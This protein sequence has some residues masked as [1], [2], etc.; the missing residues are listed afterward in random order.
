MDEQQMQF[1]DPDWQPSE[2]A[3]QGVINLGPREQPSS[4]ATIPEEFASQEIP[5]RERGKLEPQLRSRRKVWFIVVPL[6]VILCLALVGA[7]IL[8]FSSHTSTTSA[9][10]QI[11]PGQPGVA[12]L[13]ETQ[14]LPVHD[15]KPTSSADNEPIVVISDDVGS[16]HVHIGGAFD[17]VTVTATEHDGK[18]NFKGMTVITSEGGPNNNTL[19]I[20][21]NSDTGVSNTRS[22][23]LDITVPNGSSI[24]LTEGSG[25]VRIDGI[26]SESAGG[27]AQV[28]ITSGSVEISGV[29]GGI[30]VQ[31][32]NAP[33]A[34]HD[35]GGII[36]ATTVNSS[37]AALRLSGQ[38]TLNSSTG[39]I[40]AN[41]VQFGGSFS[42][43]GP[44]SITLL[45]ATLNQQTL[46]KVDSG[47]IN[48]QGTIQPGANVQF[49]SGSGAITIALPA[50]TAFQLDFGSISG[51]LKNDFGSNNVGSGRPATLQITTD[52]GP[53]FIKKQ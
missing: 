45:N 50:S 10:V 34:L 27:N 31:S 19:T 49:E 52:N 3:K 29:E 2:H 20:T 28:K 46:L 42:T 47:T 44:G 30:D 15:Y 32:Q 5:Y 4:F 23:D 16:V 38:I 14:V 39:S 43:G 51:T 41:D 40:M 1:A 13:T 22:I 48:F 8:P 25:A 37:I 21:A 36:S 17:S 11:K 53:A 9:P 33:V 35:L 7:L 6:L 12:S 18:A 24:Q 26:G